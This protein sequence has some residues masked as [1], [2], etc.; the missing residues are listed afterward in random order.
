MI[1]GEVT[2][3][4]LRKEGTAVQTSCFMSFADRNDI[5]GIKRQ[6]VDAI[7]D[8]TEDK[9]D[10]YKCVSVVVD[11]PDTDHYLTA[12]VTFDE[13]GEEWLKTMAMH[14]ERQTIH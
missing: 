1:R 7:L 3:M 9:D 4:F 12:M 6:V 10:Q 13:E 14:E 11:I 2:F 5:D 8:F